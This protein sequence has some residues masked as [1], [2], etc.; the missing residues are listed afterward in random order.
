MQEEKSQHRSTTCLHSPPQGSV[1]QQWSTDHSSRRASK[2]VLTT[3]CF[4]PSGL[5][6]LA[7]LA[8]TKPSNTG[9]NLI[10]VMSILKA[11]GFPPTQH[12]SNSQFSFP[13]VGWFCWVFL[14]VLD[15]DTFFL[16][17]FILFARND[18]NFEPS[19]I[20]LLNCP[21]QLGKILQVCP[22]TFK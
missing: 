13:S 6:A 18:L 17:F 12:A 8:P 21:C 10:L 11:A 20:K 19:E 16:V 7:L 9:F 4:A 14:W 5:P 2:P 3:P 22:Q 1:N 15:T